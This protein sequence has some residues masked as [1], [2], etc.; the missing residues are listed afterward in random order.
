MPN[1]VRVRGKKGQRQMIKK[2][3]SEKIKGSMAIR[4]A[5][6]PH[7]KSESFLENLPTELLEEIFIYGT[8]FSLPL[9]S[10]RIHGELNSERIKKL[11]LSRFLTH[12]AIDA[13]SEDENSLAEIQSALLR[14]KWLTYPVLRGS[15]EEFL[16]KAARDRLKSFTNHCTR[17]RQREAA[18]DLERGCA[19]FFDQGRTNPALKAPWIKTFDN[20]E[21]INDLDKMDDTKIGLAFYCKG[22]DGT[23]LAFAFHGKLGHNAKLRAI[24]YRPVKSVEEDPLRDLQTIATMPAIAKGCRLPRKVLHG[25]WTE[26]HGYLLQLLSYAGADFDHHDLDA[27]AAA[28]EGLIDAIRAECWPAIEALINE[29]W[30]WDVTTPIVKPRPE[31]VVE[32]L[33]VAYK[34]PPNDFDQCR[35]LLEKLDNTEIDNVEAALRKWMRKKRVSKKF[36]EYVLFM[37]D[38]AHYT[39]EGVAP[40]GSDIAEFEDY[41]GDDDLEYAE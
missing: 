25:A 15:Q 23:V 28:E 34:Y 27:C 21:L 16:I 41:S 8:N 9:V 14:L 17:E 13:Y 29:N 1:M 33:S 32:C 12:H 11:L 4:P 30:W 31:H 19:L 6:S 5:G 39:P 26:E 40:F 3:K 37:I 10:R 35:L 38:D 20:E 2:A 36:K 24:E 7:Q 22:E 18:A